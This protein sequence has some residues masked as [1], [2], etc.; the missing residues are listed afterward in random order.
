MSKPKKTHERSGANIIPEGE[1]L[2]A[3]GKAEELAKASLPEK[4]LHGCSRSW[5]NDVS[6][7]PRASTWKGR[8]EGMAR[9]T[10]SE[11][12]PSL[13]IKRSD[14][15]KQRVDEELASSANPAA[16]LESKIETQKPFRV[17]VGRRFGIFAFSR[18]LD[19]I[20]WHGRTR[21]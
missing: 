14:W 2:R 7:K 19:L 11:I 5:S 3:M 12:C 15:D 13:R 16:E 10:R 4:K 6:E 9:E 21:K 8:E 17:W 18:I 1:A 20:Q